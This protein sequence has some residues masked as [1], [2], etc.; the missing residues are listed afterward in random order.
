MYNITGT[1]LVA[2]WYRLCLPIQ[3]TWVQS[4]GWKRSPGEGNDNLFQYS[5]LENPLD[6]GAWW[7]TVHRVA[8]SQ[9]WLSK[10]H[11]YTITIILE[12]FPKELNW[13]I[14]FNSSAFTVCCAQSHL[15]LCDP[16]DCS[17]PDSSVCGIFQQEYWSGL[18]F[19]SPVDLP[20]PGIQSESLASPALAGRFFTTEP[21]SL[22]DGEK[23][24]KIYIYIYIVPGIWL[25]T[26][27]STGSKTLSGH[28]EVQCRWMLTK[29]MI[30]FSHLPARLLPG[31][32]M[33][34][35]LGSG[36][37]SRSDACAILSWDSKDPLCASPCVMVT[38]KVMFSIDSDL[39]ICLKEV[40]FVDSRGF[41]TETVVLLVNKHSSFLDIYIA[42]LP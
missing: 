14:I 32:A 21:P 25:N 16:M 24:K 3:E 4:L 7:V 22:V 17:L 12:T 19:L 29:H 27:D 33:R 31:R 26:R 9:T 8:K 20:N 41:S 13:G 34:L 1:S 2:Q 18:P 23:K 37:L 10:Q 6:T 40:H 30:L 35:V 36:L 42:S 39:L 15:T 38:E 5:C 28:K 11:Q